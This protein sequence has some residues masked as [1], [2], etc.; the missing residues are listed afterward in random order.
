MI[1]PRRLRSVLCGGLSLKRAVSIAGTGLVRG[2]T[3]P[4]VLYPAVF[5]VA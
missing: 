5:T 1:L 2:L 3:Q 4:G